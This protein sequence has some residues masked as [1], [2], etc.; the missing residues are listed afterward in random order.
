M[1]T[2]ASDAARIVVSMLLFATNLEQWCATLP[3]EITADPLWRTPA[4]RFGLFLADA[5]V[6]DFTAIERHRPTRTWAEQLLR[7]V[8]S[9]SA[10][11]AE[12]YSRSAGPDRARFY[13]YA[14]GSARESRDWY[15][16][17]RRALKPE[18][19]EDRL[20]GLSRI[21]RILTAAIPQERGK[22]LRVRD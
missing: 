7:A 10:N 16:K 17:C 14:N 20:V 3:P 1:M 11:L 6:D 9:I 22:D 2:H 13:E 12:G 19:V 15:Y 4:Y 21:V 5:A 18:L 8:G